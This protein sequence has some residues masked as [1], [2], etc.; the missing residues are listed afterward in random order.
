VATTWSASQRPGP[1]LRFPSVQRVDAWLALVVLTVQVA[2]AV[3]IASHHPGNHIS[4]GP[5]PL[6]LLLAGPA[7]LLLRST[8]PGVPLAVALAAALINGALGYGEGP[9]FASLVVAV[10]AALA[11]GRRL[12]GVAAFAVGYV[13]FQWFVPLMG[14]GHFP[15]LGGSL[16]LAAWLLVLFGIG[17]TIRYRSVRAAEQARVRE[18]ET[19]QRMSEER[20]RI[21]RELHDVLAHNIS[22]INVQAGTTLHRAHRSEQDAYRALDTIK[23]VSQ[24]TLGEL[25]SLLGALR[26]VDEPVPRAPT[27]GLTRLDDLVASAAASGVTVTLDCT[28]EPR[29]LP[30]SVDL[31][32]YRIV[33]EAL[34]N[35]ARHARPPRAVVRITYR[36]DDVMVEVDDEGRPNGP[37]VAGT[38]MTGMAERASTLGGSFAAGPRPGGGFQ[39]RACL[40]ARSAP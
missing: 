33:Q 2:A 32:C 13:G 7:A 21:A 25:R 18:A 30:A 22:L 9:L 26:Q 5:L 36:P 37:V 20:L 4:L 28:G 3:G 29:T 16:G 19:R 11:T 14:Q 34:T 40:P 23:Q 6:L 38:G 12:A 1:R 31:A 15:S 17:E 10:V 24:D 39:V 8:Y 35:V 27:P